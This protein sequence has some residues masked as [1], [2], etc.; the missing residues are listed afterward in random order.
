MYNARN[1]VIKFDGYKKGEI[2]VVDT[3]YILKDIIYR[4][5]RLK[6]LGKRGWLNMIVGINGA[7]NKLAIELANKHNLY[8]SVNHPSDVD[9]S[10][11]WSFIIC[12]RA[13]V[14]AIGETGIV[15]LDKIINCNK[16]FY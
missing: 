12:K 9:G 16:L 6:M 13:R 15:I 8:A 2:I 3:P 4:L 7:S 5:E 10:D 11:F 14:V 1:P